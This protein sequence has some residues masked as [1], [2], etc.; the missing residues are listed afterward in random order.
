MYP[1]MMH[2]LCSHVVR[3]KRAIVPEKQVLSKNTGGYVCIFSSIFSIFE[4][5]HLIFNTLIFF[6]HLQHGYVANLSKV[7]LGGNKK[8]KK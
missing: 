6:C 5:S 3:A 8:S 7:C 2:T 1:G 4:L